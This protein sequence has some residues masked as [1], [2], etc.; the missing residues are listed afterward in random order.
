MSPSLAPT[1]LVSV[2]LQQGFSSCITFGSARVAALGQVEEN[3]SCGM[4]RSDGGGQLWG[5]FSSMSV[6]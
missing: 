6:A 2:A 3:V 4:P 1:D 5:R